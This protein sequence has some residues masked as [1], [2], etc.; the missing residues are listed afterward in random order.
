MPRVAAVPDREAVVKRPPD[1]E[2]TT[3][4]RF[5]NF[6][7][8]LLAAVGTLF[9][10]CRTDVF[11]RQQAVKTLMLPYAPKELG[12]RKIIHREV[13][14][15]LSRRITTWHEADPA[16]TT[17]IAGLFQSGKTCLTEH[18]LRGMPGVVHIDVIDDA[19]K[20]ALLHK[21]GVKDAEMME[22]VFSL[23]AAKLANKRTTA[24]STVPIVV[25]DVPR[26]STASMSSISTFCKGVVSDRRRVHVIVLASAV[27]CALGIDPGGPDRRW[28][29][30]CGDLSQ[31]EA[32]Q[33]LESRG[34]R[35]PEADRLIQSLGGNAG[36]LAGAATRLSQSV[37]LE[38]IIE[39]YLEVCDVQLQLALAMMLKDRH[40]KDREVGLE[41]VEEILGS[42][43]ESKA[44]QKL[45][46]ADWILAKDIATRI[47][48]GDA[49][50]IYYHTEENVWRFSSPGHRLAAVKRLGRS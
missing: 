2:G 39:D 8:L 32:R 16:S 44:S 46:N 24:D 38:R 33:L 22:E 48:Q 20:T 42:E 10:W 35:Q 34:I 40:G 3:E 17:I 6:A 43:E 4:R 30:W 47:K 23:V 31:E 25:L 12:S 5:R 1:V 45:W 37:P 19:W 28:D 41:I 14:N 21:M 15:T 18:I 36:R 9:A 49:H 27:T 13:M 26:D 50:G 11:Q 29:L 7:S